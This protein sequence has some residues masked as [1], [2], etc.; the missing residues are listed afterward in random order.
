[1]PEAAG[2]SN[3][4]LCR[5]RP[6][7]PLRFTVHALPKWIHICGIAGSIALLGWADCVTG[8]ELNFIL[9]YFLPVI[10]AAWQFGESGVIIVSL[11]TAPVWLSARLLA[12]FDYPSSFCSAWNLMI[13]VTAFIVTGLLAAR[14]KASLEHAR[15]VSEDLKRILSELKILEGLV[16][17]CS[18]CHKIRDSSGSWQRLESY[19][20]GN[21]DA[22]LSHGFCPDCAKIAMTEAGFTPSQIES[23][24]AALRSQ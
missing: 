24:L 18:Q 3:S 4:I 10:W 14:L 1:M 11:L 17:I 8:Y 6:S 7:G 9:F 12:G 19:I 23:H 16:P 22:K 2:S 15:T 13:R 5:S 20:E 21:T